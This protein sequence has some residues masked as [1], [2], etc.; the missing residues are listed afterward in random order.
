VS[1]VVAQFACALSGASADD[2]PVAAGPSA[3][4]EDALID[5]TCALVPRRLYLQLAR[6]GAFPAR[7]FGKRVYAR[8]GDVRRVFA[9]HGEKPGRPAR[10]KEREGDQLDALRM[11]VGLKPRGTML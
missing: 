11:K 5:Q 2:L 9:E 7:K 3:L 4:H 8:W 10:P 6:D 1:E